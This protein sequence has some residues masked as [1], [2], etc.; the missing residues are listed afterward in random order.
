MSIS[1]LNKTVLMTIATGAM[2]YRQETPEGNV[3]TT[4]P[5]AITSPTPT[6][7]ESD[8]ATAEANAQAAAELK[9]K[10]L[11]DV[12][13][14]F[15][16]TVD[17]KEVSFYFRTVTDEKTKV[18]TKR[19]TVEMP[20]PVPS[21]EGIIKI[22]EN[23]GK[24][25]ELLQEAVAQVVIDQAREWVN[26][27]ENASADNAPY[28]KFTW[29]AIANLPKAERRGG[30]IPK[31]TWDDFAAEYVSIMPSL[32]NKTKEQV[33]LAAKVF[34]S[35]FVN[36]KTNKPVLKVL[37]DQLAI[38]VANTQKAEE[39]EQPIVWLSNKLETLINT[40]D[41]NLLNNL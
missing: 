32:T 19:P 21:F 5:D 28:D 25:A 17:V 37:Q 3:A 11:A 7:N 13:A 12:K 15:D 8:V 33:E 10:R 4:N 30:G 26:D 34:V 35:K 24:G 14:K 6:P 38:F 1:N 31:E 27:N 40:D 29:E 23:G 20:V 18:K 41:S 9:A 22:L 2:L 16:N 36:A 39:L